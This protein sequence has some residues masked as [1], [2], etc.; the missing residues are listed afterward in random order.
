MS[1][2]PGEE[3]AADVRLSD[4]GQPFPHGDPSVCRFYQQMEHLR[5]RPSP[6]AVS[7]WQAAAESGILPY[8]GTA[9]IL[10]SALMTG[11]YMPHL[12]WCRRIFQRLQPPPR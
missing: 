1:G 11:V 10:Y 5:K 12:C 3:D 8:L 2:R 9:V 6:A 4:C 7:L